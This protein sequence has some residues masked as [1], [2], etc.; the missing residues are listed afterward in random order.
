MVIYV[1]LMYFIKSEINQVE[2]LITL[3]VFVGIF[4]LLSGHE[5]KVITLQ[6]HIDKYLGFCVIDKT[7]QVVSQKVI[8]INDNLRQ[9]LQGIIQWI[10]EDYKSSQCRK[11]IKWI[12]NKRE[13]IFSS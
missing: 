9:A 7:D 10:I 11:W 3:S 8:Y 1:Y 13:I 4:I 5:V 6:K 2:H 12:K